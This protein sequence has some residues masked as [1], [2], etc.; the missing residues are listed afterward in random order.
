MIFAFISLRAQTA[1]DVIHRY[2]DFIGG[3]KKWKNIKTIVTSGEYDYGGMKFPF[4]TFSKAP[5]L[6]KFVV[7]LDNKYYAQ[8]F[9]GKSGWKIDAFKNETKPTSLGGIEA[10]AMANEADVELEPPFIN[11]RQKG[12]Q[13]ILEGKDSINKTSC[14]KIK[15][16]R[17]TGET[18]TYYF[19]VESAEMILKVATSKNAEMQ[20]AVLNTMIGDYRDIGGVKIPFK[21]VSR[22]GDQNILTITI[23]KAA[24]NTPISEQEFKPKH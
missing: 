10:R 12:H 21:S 15:F 7:R 13:A 22:L 8:A 16:I 6:Y 9:D 4:A 18:E 17:H 24:I 3:E 11:Y 19:T 2:I 20:G 1:D 14:F 23:E 5:N